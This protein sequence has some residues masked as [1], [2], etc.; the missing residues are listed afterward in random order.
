MS[1]HAQQL[2]HFKFFPSN[3]QEAD[4]KAPG[5]TDHGWVVERTLSTD[6]GTALIYYRL[7]A[8]DSCVFFQ[9]MLRNLGGSLPEMSE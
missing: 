9:S 5:V 8:K 1:V 4:W 2:A 3:D 7:L 6:G